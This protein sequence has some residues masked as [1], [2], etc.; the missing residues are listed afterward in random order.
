M[1]VVKLHL[2]SVLSD[3]NA[4]YLVADIKKYL[5]TPMKKYQYM[6]IPV[7]HIP[8]DVME[9]YNLKWLIINK[10]ILVE[11]CKD[12]YGLPH[13]GLITQKCINAHLLKFGYYKCKYTP[14]VYDHKIRTT[15]FTLV[16]DDF[17]IKYN[18]KEDATHLLNCLRLLYDITIYCTYTLYIG[19][20]L[21]WDYIR[22]I[23][24]LSIPGYIEKT[25]HRFCV[26]VSP[27][28][29]HYPRQWIT[30]V[31]D[32]KVQMTIPLDF[33]HTLGCDGKRHIQEVFGVI[34]YYTQA[35]NSLA[36]VALSSI[37]TEQVKPTEFT[38][39]AAAQLLNYCAIYP[40]PVLR[41][42]ATDMVLS[43]YNDAYLFI[44]V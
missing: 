24:C 10:H 19:L 28:L 9:Q 33:L 1:W 26:S 32:T 13:A 39:K 16:M 44:S 29:Q 30:P 22:R 4:S 15:T 38:G 40:N 18:T 27:E 8:K 36:L 37:G 23:V 42:C 25:L 34:F 7:E 35:L 41:F 20:T 6:H 2:N 21:R 12:I 3:V 17:G 11:N 5:N 31:Y 43:V 14:V